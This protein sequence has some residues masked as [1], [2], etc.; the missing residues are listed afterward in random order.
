[1]SNVVRVCVLLCQDLLVVPAARQGGG[2]LSEEPELTAAQLVVT[3]PQPDDSG[4]NTLDR[5]EW[6][7]AMAAADGLKLYLDA[8]GSEK[9]IESDDDRRILCEYHE[10]W[11]ALHG[12]N[13]ELVSGKHRDPAAGPFRTLNQ[14]ADEGG[15]A[16]LFLRWHALKEKPTCR[17]ATTGGL[18]PG[19]P[20]KLEATIHYLRELQKS[21]AEYTIPDEHLTYVAKLHSAIRTYG[22]K[23]LPDNW[24]PEDDEPLPEEAQRLQVAR[25]LSVLNIQHGLI[26]RN[27]V[28]H[29][30]P[31]MYAKP[32]VEQLGLDV[33]PD[34]LW[35][36]VL[37]LFRTRMRAAGPRPDGAL[38]PVLSLANGR[39]PSSRGESERDLMARLVTMQDIDIAVV[40]AISNP[41]AYESLSPPVR[42]SRAAV[43]MKKGKCSD[44]SIE[45]GEQLRR[46]YLKYWRARMSGDP[47][48]LAEREALRR[49]LLRIS[50][51]VCNPSLRAVEE[52]GTAFWFAIQTAL[53]EVPAEKLPAG[54]D[55]DLLLGGISDLA[56]AC[57]IWFSDSFDVAAE[58]A[59]LRER[60]QGSAA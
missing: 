57:Q 41:S 52:W 32:V 22:G 45:R 25:F 29:A 56:N 55:S 18:A 17:L 42:M 39:A 27:Y 12:A 43:K 54:M 5:Y 40:T 35:N 33:A 9:R 11:V 53:D 10:D 1:M 16:H 59:N 20:Q 60:N 46:D 36:A 13:A 34:A 26:M 44:N 49:L 37:G 2:A 31:S 51:Q 38:P 48:A 23:N 14:L 50:D 4:A 24:S 7:A 15:V 8:L 30:A 58:I 3:V 19:D 28:S 47:T 21:G 6:Q